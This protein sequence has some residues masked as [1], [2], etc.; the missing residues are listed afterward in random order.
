MLPPVEGEGM[1]REV[2]RGKDDVSHFHLEVNQCREMK[3]NCNQGKR[4][5]R[6]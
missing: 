4:G 5:K 6:W 2:D 3:L 1:K